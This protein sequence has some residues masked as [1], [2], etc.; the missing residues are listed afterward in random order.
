M[1]GV[2][3]RLA[4]DAE[5][6]RRDYFRLSVAACYQKCVTTTCTKPTWLKATAVE[7][8]FD[9]VFLFENFSAAFL[10]SVLAVC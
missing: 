9:C 3:D 5:S 2:A 1:A 8:V 7:I 6:S 10:N 4:D